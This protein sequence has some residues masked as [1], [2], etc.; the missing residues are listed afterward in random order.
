MIGPRTFRSTTPVVQSIR[1][2]L[3]WSILFSP[4]EY[5]QPTIKTVWILT[6][7]L[8]ALI[9]WCRQELVVMSLWWWVFVGLNH[10]NVKILTYGWFVKHHPSL[11]FRSL[12]LSCTQSVS[13]KN[14]NL[15]QTAFEVFSKSVKACKHIPWIGRLK[16]WLLQEAFSLLR[17]V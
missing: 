14:D 6:T 1:F 7:Y 3:K 4:S 10:T 13:T 11:A 12:Q 2:Q 15:E 16:R 5:W 17:H 9:P 8:Y